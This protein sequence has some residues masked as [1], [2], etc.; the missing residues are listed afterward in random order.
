MGRRQG[1]VI[2][3]EGHVKG[4]YGVHSAVF[5]VK[6][7]QLGDGYDEWGIYRFVCRAA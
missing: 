5:G 1:F 3:E 6:M 2:V 4:L 7:G